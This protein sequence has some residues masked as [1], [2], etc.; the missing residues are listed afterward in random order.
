M[1]KKNISL[2]FISA[3]ALAG[4]AST[5]TGDLYWKYDLGA[6]FNEMKALMDSPEFR[7]QVNDSTHYT[8]PICGFADEENTTE[9]IEYLIKVGGDVTSCRER[10][11]FTT[12]LHV[13]VKG[14][15]IE[16]ASIL[17]ANGADPNVENYDGETPLGIAEKEGYYKIAKMINS[18]EE[19]W[20]KA[21][22][23]GEVNA[24]EE[25]LEQ[26]PN[27]MHSAEAKLKLA[28]LESMS[29]PEANAGSVVAETETRELFQEG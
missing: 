20:Q 19:D 11:Y 28:L 8:I 10:G 4:C 1:I 3:A 12:P 14:N 18:Y 21:N 5:P 9:I 7:A 26:Y 16:N 15:S 23:E 27:A 17:L 13:A 29:D 6:D 25:Y 24:F 22:S 2:A